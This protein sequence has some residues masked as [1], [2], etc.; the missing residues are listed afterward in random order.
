MLYYGSDSFFVIPRYVAGQFISFK[1]A[2]QQIYGA[3]KFELGS[4]RQIKA[5]A[6]SYRFG[7]FNPFCVL[8]LI[9][10]LKS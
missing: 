7:Y 1:S 9:D 5:D 8:E 3:V 6:K 4:M 2:A 10:P